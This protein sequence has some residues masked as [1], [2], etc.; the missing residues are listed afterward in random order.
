MFEK[1]ENFDKYA[2]IFATDFFVKY[3]LAIFILVGLVSPFSLLKRLKEYK[4]SYV[5]QEAGRD[6]QSAQA[7]GQGL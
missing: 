6:S 7:R 3:F 5:N 4:N 2:D 1:H